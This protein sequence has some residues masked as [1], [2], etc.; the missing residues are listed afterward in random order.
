[1]TMKNEAV[2]SPFPE[3]LSGATWPFA[4]LLAL[5]AAGLLAIVPSYHAYFFGDE[6]FY[7]DSAIRM[8][9][10]GQ[11]LTPVYADGAPRFNKPV[12]T[13]WA[14]LASFRVFGISI[15]ASRLPALLAGLLALMLT[16]R[17]AARLFN[18]HAA[19]FAAM[20]VLASNP[21]F[22]S[23]AMRATPDIL[24]VL[25][26][27]LSLSGFLGLL[28]ED[29][30]ARVDAWAAYL[31]AGLAV[32]AKGMLGLL[33][34]L[35]VALFVLA[36]RDRRARVRALFHPLPMLVGLI[37]AL[38]W[39][40]GVYLRFGDLAIRGFLDDQVG[41]HRAARSIGKVGTNLIQ[42]TFGL[43][44]RFFPWSILLAAAAF[45][46]RRA[47]QSALTA[48]ASV[49]LFLGAW[50]VLLVLVFSPSS[51]TRPRYLLPAFPLLAVAAA[52]LLPA[53]LALPAVIRL[54]RNLLKLV[55]VLLAGTGLALAG[56]ALFL[57]IP[58]LTMAAACF[59]VLAITLAVGLRRATPN[60]LAILLAAASF[61]T[62][63]A[64]LATVRPA[65]PSIPAYDLVSVLREAGHDR[66][67]LP[68]QTAELTREQNNLYK[69]KFAS[70]VRIISGGSI[71]VERRAIP[72]YLA[73]NR[74]VMPMICAGSDVDLFPAN[75]FAAVRAGR[76]FTANIRF[77]DLRRLAAEP[78]KTRAIDRLACP[79]YIIFPRP[80]NQPTPMPKE[81]PHGH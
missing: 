27:L 12:L 6:H 3:P 60:R 76:S 57:A 50:Y 18:S 78:D 68:H 56:A 33:I 34:L 23:A 35:F 61:A 71:R 2:S 53:A 37:L 75:R 15:L 46:N 8:S 79:Y 1:M 11:Y 31:G 17:L 59:A 66:V 40:A 67:F 65:F 81:T 9:Q 24:L 5:F 30:P 62:F 80:G 70:Q 72:H 47:L 21:L 49:F 44:P 55:I 20:L 42:Y 43:I 13:Y 38:G 74:P 58:R 41:T 36:R 77:A 16:G 73:R 19:A 48:R 54:T 51:M 52:G 10:T 26:S 29:R 69:E 4:L 7:T 25:S 14:I 45:V 28:V 22:I 63:W 39:F 32:S 64:F